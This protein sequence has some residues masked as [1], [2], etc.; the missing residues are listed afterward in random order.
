MES[1]TYTS[2]HAPAH[3]NMY[4]QDVCVIC[5]CNGRCTYTSLH[6]PNT[7]QNTYAHIYL[8]VYACTCI[9]VHANE[10]T[11]IHTH[12]WY[13]CTCKRTYTH[14]H[15]YVYMHLHI[16]KLHTYMRTHTHICNSPYCYIYIPKKLALK[17]TLPPHLLIP[18][19][20]TTLFLCDRSHVRIHR[21]RSAC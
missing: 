14:T 18:L 19:T 16:T 20:T 13:T 2:L 8:D 15:T 1:C 10:A 11:H 17:L 3:N 6:A 21:G 12:T 7:L 9:H 5:R 4:V